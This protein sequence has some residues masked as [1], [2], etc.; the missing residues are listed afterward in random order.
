MLAYM[1]RKLSTI[2]NFFLISST[3]LDK[4]HLITGVS[5]VDSSIS[6]PFHIYYGI[7]DEGIDAHQENDNQQTI[8]HDL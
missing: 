2:V 6:Y 7:D 3:E 8:H 5:I 4:T 1:V